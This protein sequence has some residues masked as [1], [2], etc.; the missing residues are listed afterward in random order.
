MARGRT[1]T[2]HSAQDNTVD[3]HTLQATAQRPRPILTGVDVGVAAVPYA[4]TVLRALS[5]HDAAGQ[6]R[7]FYGCGVRPRPDD[8]GDSDK[9]VFKLQISISHNRHAVTII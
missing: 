5:T 2:V 9:T 7:H 3:V 1:H 6:W 8:R 4:A